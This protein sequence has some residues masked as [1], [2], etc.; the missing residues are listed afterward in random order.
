MFFIQIFKCF[1]FKYIEEG[2][3]TP[4]GLP[5]CELLW[6]IFFLEIAVKVSDLVKGESNT[7][8]V[9]NKKVSG[10]HLG[11]KS[12]PQACSSLYKRKQKEKE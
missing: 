6:E 8:K 11:P 7:L 12:V 4:H 1:I 9:F 10:S 2:G 5:N 3:K